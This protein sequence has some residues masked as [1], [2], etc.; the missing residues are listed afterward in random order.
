M[1]APLFNEAF[2]IFHRDE[3]GKPVRIFPC[4]TNVATY[5]S[6]SI[7]ICRGMLKASTVQD[8]FQILADQLGPKPSGSWYQNLSEK[9]IAGLF[10]EK[11]LDSFP[12]I[13]VDYSMKNPDAV[14]C[15]YRR[16]LGL[17]GSNFEGRKM[18]IVLNGQVSR[19]RL[20]HTSPMSK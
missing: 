16:G 14:G 12:L 17:D 13:F 7:M 2:I 19:K 15:S 11:I 20:G 8:A 18:C 9:D 5:V 10:I 4:D 3:N 6:T 1:A